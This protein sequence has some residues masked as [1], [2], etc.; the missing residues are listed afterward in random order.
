M[1]LLLLITSDSFPSGL[2]FTDF[3]DTF[4]SVL[5]VSSNIFTALTFDED[6]VHP[7]VLYLVTQESD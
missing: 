1:V 2:Y 3:I 5:V 4:N 7:I 6:V